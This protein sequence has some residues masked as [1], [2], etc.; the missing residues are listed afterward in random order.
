MKI[1]KNYKKSICG[2]K[3]SFFAILFD[4]KK[5]WYYLNYLGS[6]KIGDCLI[7]KNYKK[8]KILNKHVLNTLGVIY[9]LL[10]YPFKW[11][12]AFVTAP[13][14]MYFDG[15]RNFIKDGAWQ[16]NVRFFNWANIVFVIAL[17]LALVLN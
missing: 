2:V 12:I 17:L 13:F 3:Y 4:G 16:N 15:C 7:Y 5:Y 8:N 6:S 9:T 10:I 14:F 11:P 1:L